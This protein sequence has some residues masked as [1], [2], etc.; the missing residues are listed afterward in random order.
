MHEFTGLAR[1]WLTIISVVSVW[2][3]IANMAIADDS[4]LRKRITELEAENRALRKIIA[5]IQN[6]L[7]LVPEN[8]QPQPS[9][10]KTLRILV[11]PGEWGDSRIEDIRK[12][13]SSA[14]QTIWTQLPGDGLAPIHVARSNSGPITLYQRGSGHEYVVKLDTSNRAW[15]QCAFQFAH[16]FCHIICN[17]R[18]VPNRQLWFE[19]TICE[20]ASLF[21]LRRMAE[22]W[23]T[24]APYSNWKSYS[25]SLGKY[26]DN[27]IKSLAGKSDSIK[28]LYAEQKS[29]LEE[30]ATNRELNGFM[31]VKLLPIF[32]ETPSAWQAVRYLNLGPKEENVSFENYLSGWRDRVPSKHKHVVERIA[33]EFGIALELAA[34]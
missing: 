23:K 34:N 28:A 19:E 2:F 29:N 18:S 17:Y 15:A 14:A 4:Q 24:N 20:T 22:T 9:N 11:L 10:D 33:K 13:C 30:N 3:A 27:R 1:R 31:A 6:T 16:E 7:R 32:E 8:K 12:V 26:A 5:D 25:V 21:A